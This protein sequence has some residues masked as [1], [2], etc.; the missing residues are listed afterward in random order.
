MKAN[1]SRLPAL[2][3]RERECVELLARTE[4]GSWEYWQRVSAL[5]DVVSDRIACELKL[6]AAKDGG[7]LDMK[8]E[9]A[10]LYVICPLH[11][12]P[13]E[14]LSAVVRAVAPGQ[15]ATVCPRCIEDGKKIREERKIELS[16]TMVDAKFKAE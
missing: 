11:S 8:I 1:V 15:F 4:R 2:R 14:L 6:E 3:A 13:G 5:N 12:K 16:R 9:N 7:K 10:K